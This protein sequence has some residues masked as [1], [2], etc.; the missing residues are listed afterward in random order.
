M[1][2]IICPLRG[3]VVSHALSSG[4]VTTIYYDSTN[5]IIYIGNGGAGATQLTP[6]YVGCSISFGVTGTDQFSSGATRVTSSYL[7]ADIPTFYKNYSTVELLSGAVGGIITKGSATATGD[8]NLVK[9]NGI[10]TCNP[11]TMQNSPSN[12]GWGNLTVIGDG[13]NCFQF[14]YSAGL[15]F[16]SYYTGNLSWSDWK[17]L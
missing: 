4:S 16:R 14:L 9:N 1:V 13:S 7:S 12:T 8:F 15:Y 3:G 10:F 2:L 17:T 6:Q 11:S 5:N